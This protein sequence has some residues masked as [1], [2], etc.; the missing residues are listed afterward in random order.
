MDSLC[1]IS[2]LAAR[3]KVS[4]K[5]FGL[6]NYRLQFVGKVHLYFLIILKC[7]DHKMINIW[8]II[9]ILL[10]LP[11]NVTKSLQNHRIVYKTTV[12][13]KIG[14]SKLTKL[15]GEGYKKIFW[16][17]KSFLFFGFVNFSKNNF[18]FVNFILVL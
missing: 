12:V 3:G 7:K 5:P 13:Y 11:V 8:H 15:W 18:G 4:I 10:R 16:L 6:S 14:W 9:I 17:T 2:S 1:V